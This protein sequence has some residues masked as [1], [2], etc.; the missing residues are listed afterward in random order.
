MFVKENP[1]RKKKKKRYEL[2]LSCNLQESGLLLCNLQD[3]SFLSWNLHDRN[4]LIGNLVHRDVA[5]AR[6]NF[7]L[8][9]VI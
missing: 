5:E 7:R 8:L 2:P 6:F 3:S 9:V 1:D 4:F